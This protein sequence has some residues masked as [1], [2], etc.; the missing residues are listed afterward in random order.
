MNRRIIAMGLTAILAFSMTACGSGESASTGDTSSGSQDQDSGEVTKL[1][2]TF[3]TWTGAPADTQAVQDAMNE[4]TRD[5]LGIEVELQILDFASYGQSMTLALSAGEQIDIAVCSSGTLSYGNAVTQGYLMDLEENDL[6]AT[7]GQ[8]IIEAMGWDYIDACRVGGV[9]YGLPNNRD[10]ATGRGCAAIATEYLDGIGYEFDH[11]AEIVYISI[12]E[13]ND[14]YAQLHEAYP[15]LEVYRPASTAMGQFSNVDALGGN[16]FGVLLDNGAELTVENLFTS[17][18]YREYCERIYM[19]NQS[20]YISQDAA[21][22]TTSVTE[23]VKAGTLMS[24]T[25]GGKPGI[26]VQETSLCGRDMTIFQT[27]DNVLSSTAVSSFPWVI[28]I[29]S[30][31]PEAAMTYLNELYTNEDLANLLG[32]GIEGE[33]YQIGE[34]GLATYAD[35]VDATTSGWNHSMQWLM[36]NEFI[37]YVWEGNDPDLWEQ[38]EEF[39]NSAIVSAAS[40]FTFDSS[41]V[42]NEIT[43]VT[44]VYNEYQASVEYGF[45]DPETGIAE[46][47]ERLM[48]AGLQEIIDEKQ[49]QLDEW[50]ALQ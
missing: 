46:M 22:D 24:Y 12:D 27:M 33:H 4:I 10:I 32:W 28:P 45:V 13:L 5:S 48:A 49:R 1:V 18:F 47:N 42:A 26:K 7:Y 11:E 50:A 34:D 31:D 43:A 8:G 14:I 39:N 44:N 36:P 41:N 3:Y 40:G 2:M 9:L 19:Y 15:D 29:T 37:T 35:G 16:Y 30:A 23:L 20:G 38:M 6:L 17:D 21:T 25:T